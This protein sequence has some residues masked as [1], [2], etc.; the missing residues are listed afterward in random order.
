MRNKGSES[1]SRIVLRNRILP[2]LEPNFALEA[3]AWDRVWPFQSPIVARRS[4]GTL[5]LGMAKAKSRLPR[6]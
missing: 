1:Q 5:G 3:D 6:R 2:S 4:T